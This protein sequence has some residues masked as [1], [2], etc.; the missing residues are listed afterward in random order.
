MVR[1]QPAGIMAPDVCDLSV[2][3]CGCSLVTYMSSHASAWWLLVG[4]T[5][6]WQAVQSIV[7]VSSLRVH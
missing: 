3:S 2:I 6:W 1:L 5:M 4:G 7:W